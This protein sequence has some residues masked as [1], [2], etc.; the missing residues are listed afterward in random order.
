MT[1][2]IAILALSACLASC[3]GEPDAGSKSATKTVPKV[4]V[5]QA[6]GLWTTPDAGRVQTIALSQ[7]GD[8]TWDERDGRGAYGTILKSFSGR[9]TIA[10]GAMDCTRS[11]GEGSW[12]AQMGDGALVV[13]NERGTMKFSRKAATSGGPPSE[14]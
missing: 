14:G 9:C 4:V 6:A 8:Y 11:D 12:T 2:T 1:R 7:N 13:E 3:S 10:D 5:G